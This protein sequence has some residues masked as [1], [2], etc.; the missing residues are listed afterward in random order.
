[1]LAGFYSNPISFSFPPAFIREA[2]IR[3][4]AEFT[5]ED[6]SVTKSLIDTGA[7][8]LDNL[9]SDKRA[10]DVSSEAYRF[11]FEDS[12]CLKMVIDWRR[13]A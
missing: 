12:N 1:V 11:A 10:A 13:A 7:L 4:A 2:K 3:I 9:I 8:S 5:Q 6:I